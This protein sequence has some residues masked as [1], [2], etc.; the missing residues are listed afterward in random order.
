MATT[1]IPF[2][3]KFCGLVRELSPEVFVLKNDASLVQGFPD[4][5]IY[6][7]DKYIILE[8]KRSKN[9]RRRPNQAWYVDHF[10]KYTLSRFVYPENAGEVFDEICQFLGFENRHK[11]IKWF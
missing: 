2:E 7:H 8:F 4:R 5:V 10:A 6:Y 1:E 3:R 11:R 9:A